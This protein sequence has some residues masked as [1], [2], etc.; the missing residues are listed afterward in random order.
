ML[1]S[2]HNFAKRPNST[3]RPGTGTVINGQLKDTTTLLNPVVTFEFPGGEAPAYNYLSI[4]DFGNRYYFISEWAYSAGLWE[5][6]ATI[7]VLATYK[8]E[9][10]GNELYVLRSASMYNPT[11]VDDKYPARTV[12]YSNCT[13]AEN[14]FNKNWGEGHFVVGVVNGS[15]DAIGATSYY[16]L[17]NTEFRVL[18]QYLFSSVDYLNID[19]SELSQSLQKALINP[20][21]YIVSAMFFPYYFDRG[22]ESVSSIPIGWWGGA[23][24]GFKLTKTHFSVSSTI[25]VPKNPQTEAR[26]WWV[27]SAPYTTYSLEYFPFGSIPLDSQKLLNVDTLTLSVAVDLITGVA[28]L[29]VTGDDGDGAIAI[30]Q[31]Q[32]GVPIQL[33]QMSV[34]YGALASS[35]GLLTAA[36]GAAM[37]FAQFAQ[38]NKKE[39][40]N[41]L[42]GGSIAEAAGAV[43]GV[44][45]SVVKNADSIGNAI[46][47]AL[48]DVSIN[49][50]NGGM[51]VFA[52][53]VRVNIHYSLLADDDN[54]HNGRPLCEKRRIS[55]FSGYVQVQDGEIAL[56]RA[57][58]KET[59]L[60]REYLEGG[61]YY[62]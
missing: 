31:A 61:F 16:V 46:N 56:S 18:M 33:A 6:H 44:E 52:L 37:G 45:R 53:A 12:R 19:P 62:E 55:D 24:T 43:R 11:I 20:F 13:I 48:A 17:T 35:T 60:L 41:F 47:S 57:T 26:G 42:S 29:R 1:I 3:A 58:A 23:S 32:L 8:E 36:A 22:N 38:Q 25:A 30:A 15:T 14:P 21:Q 40:I 10:G 2:L 50:S 28:N 49:G 39:I 51:A 5:A 54:E 4:P 59:E 27:N 7:D 34:D 9:I